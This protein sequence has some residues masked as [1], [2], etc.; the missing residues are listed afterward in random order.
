LGVNIE[1]ELAERALEP[2]QPF[3]QHDET[4]ARK[5]R[6]R[7]KVHV[8]KSF[9]EIVVR[10]GRKAMNFLRTKM[11]MFDVVVLILAVG[12]LRRREWQIG[13]PGERIVERLVRLLRDGLE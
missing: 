3:L 4:R 6:G 9:A 8:T 1:H 2:R 5:L 13:D 12:H 10:P 11:M 7:S